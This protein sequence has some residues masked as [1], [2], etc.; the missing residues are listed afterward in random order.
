LPEVRSKHLT[1]RGLI[2]IHHR[3]DKTLSPCSASDHENSGKKKEKHSLT[4]AFGGG[5]GQLHAFATLPQEKS[6]WYVWIEGL[7]RKISPPAEN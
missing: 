4:L 2:L 7:R 6:P 5:D 3:I 1:G